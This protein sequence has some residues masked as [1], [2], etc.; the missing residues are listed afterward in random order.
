[1]S[2]D[3]ELAAIRAAR[4]NQL[5]Q[6]GGG[7]AGGPEKDEENKQRAAAEENMRQLLAT[8]L[9]GPARERRE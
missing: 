2:E 6:N 7:G 9:E 8:V 3:P 1:M 4:L 5:Q